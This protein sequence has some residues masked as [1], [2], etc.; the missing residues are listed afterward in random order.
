[1]SVQPSGSQ[2]CERPRERHRA[3]PVPRW[4]DEGLETPSVEMSPGTTL[5]YSHSLSG[6]SS[7]TKLPSNQSLPVL[8][9]EE[10]WHV[11][12]WPKRGEPPAFNS[13]ME[14]SQGLSYLLDKTLTTSLATTSLNANTEGE[15]CAGPPTCGACACQS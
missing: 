12:P 9:L 2:T 10:T 11:V 3:L 8:E 15:A 5:A 7:G 1:M 4:I 14:R 13:K 6:A